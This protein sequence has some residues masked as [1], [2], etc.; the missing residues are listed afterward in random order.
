M[1]RDERKQQRADRKAERADKRKQKKEQR[2]TAEGDD[3]RDSARLVSKLMTIYIE[4]FRNVPVLLW[5]LLVSTAL[6][7]GLPSPR[8]APVLLGG[9]F[10]PTTRGFYIPAPVFESGAM[11]LGI[12]FVACTIGAFIFRR[13]AAAKQAA[14]GEIL[15]VF[16][17]SLGILTSL[18]LVEAGLAFMREILVQDELATAAMLRGD[19]LAAGPPPFMWITTAAQMG[20][21]FI[22][23]FA[24]TFFECIE[25]DART[26]RDQ[27][28]QPGKLGHLNAV[29]P[30][31]RAAAHLVQK[32][33][34]AF[35]FTHGDRGVFRTLIGKYHRKRLYAL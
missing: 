25:D 5:I 11:L 18:A 34:V 27:L 1:S 16:W 33:H 3:L 15:P 7:A 31:R 24:L 22:L 28:G 9:G 17:I 10:V 21:G 6:S 30:V 8:Q 13:W 29:R 26:I 20:M 4:G 23:P 2:R 14:T 19:E 32:D 35:P 12:I